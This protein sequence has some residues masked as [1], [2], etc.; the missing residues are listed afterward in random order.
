MLNVTG[1]SITQSLNNNC[2]RG[3]ILWIYIWQ[4]LKR[5]KMST[6]SSF[7]F[8]ASVSEGHVLGRTDSPIHFHTRRTW[9]APR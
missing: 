1:H 6:L 5:K 4:W 9:A 3:L 8:A 7:M 2:T